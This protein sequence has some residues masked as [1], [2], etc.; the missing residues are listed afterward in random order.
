ML[1]TLQ[2]DHLNNIWWC[3]TLYSFLRPPLISFFYRQIPSA[4]PF[5]R[6]PKH[7]L[8]RHMGDRVSN[9]HKTK[10]RTVVRQR[11]WTKWQQKF[12]GFNLLLNSPCTQFWFL[13]PL[14]YIWILPYFTSVCCQSQ[15]VDSLRPSAHDC[16]LCIYAHTGTTEPL[17]VYPHT[18]SAMKKSF[19]NQQDSGFGAIHSWTPSPCPVAA[20][21]PD[22]RL[23]RVA[24]ECWQHFER[25]TMKTSCE[26]SAADWL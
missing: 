8:F 21:R 9:P 13:V 20:R 10:H 1:F 5:L 4:A 11:L 19:W 16:G 25:Q 18:P 6:H 14:Q 22:T 7:T 23:Y 24:T 15:S 12:P 2:F 17:S 3:S 26:E